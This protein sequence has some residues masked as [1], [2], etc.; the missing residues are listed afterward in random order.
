MD[1]VLSKFGRLRNHLQPISLGMGTGIYLAIVIMSYQALGWLALTIYKNPHW[2]AAMNNAPM[3]PMEI[4]LQLPLIAT[5]PIPHG[6]TRSP[7]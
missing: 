4:L 5:V 7:A 1:A 6:R 2:M 3:E